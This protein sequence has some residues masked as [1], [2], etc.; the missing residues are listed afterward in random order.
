MPTEP[1]VPTLAQVVHRAVT[2]CDPDGEDEGLARLLE[3]FQDRDEPVTAEPDVESRLAEAR[4]A[5]DPQDEDPGVL[6]ATAV[7]TYLAHRRTEIPADRDEILRLA[8]RA[9]F[10]GN[11]PPA[12]AG[13]LAAEGIDA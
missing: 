6:M 4:G 2:V 8:A 10:D 11:P 3:R 12:V 9:E 13:W 7:A 5:I 1:E